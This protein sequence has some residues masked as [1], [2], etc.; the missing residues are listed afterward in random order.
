MKTKGAR[1]YTD[2]ELELLYTLRVEKGQDYG[3]VA[4][5]FE[6]LSK[7]K[8]GIYE[9]TTTA[10]ERKC[11]DLHWHETDKPNGATTGFL[12]KVKRFFRRSVS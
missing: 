11:R 5:Q 4:K 9:R 2:E 8:P 6:I 3:E 1:N 12:D 10:L 7:F